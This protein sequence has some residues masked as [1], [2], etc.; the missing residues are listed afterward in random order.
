MSFADGEAGQEAEEG[1]GERGHCQFWRGGKSHQMIALPLV[2]VVSCRS[3]S[4]R[5]SCVTRNVMCYCFSS[6]RECTKT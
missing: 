4:V 6:G 3:H 5:W 1:E 2:V